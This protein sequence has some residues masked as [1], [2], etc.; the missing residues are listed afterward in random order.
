VRQL[1]PEYAAASNIQ[2]QSLLA[3]TIQEF[4]K[5]IGFSKYSGKIKTSGGLDLSI[6][7]DALKLRWESVPK[8][9]IPILFPLLSSKYSLKE[10]NKRLT[11]ANM[12]DLSP[13]PILPWLKNL[14]CRIIAKLS[15][16]NEFLTLFLLLKELVLDSDI[17]IVDHILPCA[18]LN[19]IIDDDALVELM[20]KEF[21]HILR[22]QTDI[23]K[24]RVISFIFI[25]KILFRIIDY[26]ESWCRHR[27]SFLAKKKLM[28]ARRSHR[29][30]NSTMGSE[31]DSASER[32]LCFL[33][34]ISF[35]ALADC[36]FNCG[37][38]SRSLLYY[39]KHIREISDSGDEVQLQDLYSRLQLIYSNL[40]EPDSIL[41][42]STKIIHPSIEQQLLEHQSLGNW[43]M[44]LNCYEL[45]DCKKNKELIIG[46]INCLKNLGQLR[47]LYF[48]ILQEV[49]F[50]R[51]IWN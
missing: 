39:E 46:R 33:G 11:M 14:Y 6:N 24:I 8:K 25:S 31:T 38:Y 3:Y 10:D 34:N 20:Q 29:I 26:L 51:F 37:D 18:V 47:K 30:L 13:L 32:V 21:T 9:Y 42:I 5:F 43:D 27:K 23:G 1:V 49:A 28:E 45:I 19:G 44:A 36:A 2:T 50:H 16:R 41:G 48:L 7:D 40:D 15:E 35:L 12:S 4:L 22:S 17:N